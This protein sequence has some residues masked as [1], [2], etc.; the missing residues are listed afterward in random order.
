MAGQGDGV[1]R[2]NPYPVRLSEA[3]MVAFGAASWTVT[4][5]W[6]EGYK[7]VVEIDYGDTIGIHWGKPETT[8]ADLI[9]IMCGRAREETA[10]A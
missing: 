9:E 6:F 4:R 7:A 8:M 5:C 3:Q 2:A 1:S 10:E